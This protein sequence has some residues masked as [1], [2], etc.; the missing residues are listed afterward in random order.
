[1]PFFLI[2]QYLFRLFSYC[3]LR[4]TVN[5]TCPL[6]PHITHP[7]SSLHD[8]SSVSGLWQGRKGL[9]FQDSRGYGYQG[10]GNPQ[11]VHFVSVSLL[12]VTC[13][14]NYVA[15]VKTKSPIALSL[16]V[17]VPGKGQRMRRPGWEPPGGLTWA[18]GPPTTGAGRHG[19]PSRDPGPSG[20]R[21]ARLHGAPRWVCPPH[22]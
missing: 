13:L 22:R 21:L 11:A 18:W 20:Q 6:L 9:G 8:R 12:A 2:F 4:S 14:E 10:L 16:C 17:V 5:E 15:F 7:H 19:G 3:C 1:M